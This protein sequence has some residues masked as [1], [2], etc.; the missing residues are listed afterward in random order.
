MGKLI[1]KNI[2]VLAVWSIGLWFF[3]AVLTP[4]IEDHIPAWKRY[5]QVQ[6]EQDLDSGALYYSN[7]PQ[8]QEAEENTRR[9]VKEGMAIRRDALKQRRQNEHE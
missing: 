3:F 7:V 8:T 2:A 5:N 4:I 9:A 6:E 1:L